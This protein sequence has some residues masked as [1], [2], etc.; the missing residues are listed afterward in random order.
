MK[1]APSPLRFMKHA[2]L[3]IDIS[4]QTA[5]YYPV[6]SQLF[7]LIISLFLRDL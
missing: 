3:L 7:W 5:L 2:P 4:S 1:Y 6:F